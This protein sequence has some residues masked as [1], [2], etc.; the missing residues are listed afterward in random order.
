MKSRVLALLGVLL[1]VSVFNVA[2]NTG[3]ALA[4]VDVDSLL[5]TTPTPSTQ[6]ESGSSSTTKEE[7]KGQSMIDTITDNLNYT[8][9]EDETV[10]KF[11][12]M[13]Q[14]VTSWVVQGLTYV[15]TGLLV[16]NKLVD[17]F[18]VAIPFTRTILANGYMGNA[19]VAG[20]PQQTMGAMGGMGMGGMG[21]MGGYGGYNRGGLFGGFGGSRYGG[22][23]GMGMGGSMMNGAMDA[24]IASQNQPARSRLQ[25]VSN[26]ALNAVATESVLGPDGQ[27]QSAFK[28]YTK[29]MLI[30]LIIAPILVV[31][32][33]TGA[34]A[35]IGFGI[36]K[37][38][39]DIAIN[40]KF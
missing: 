24:Q 30:S 21:G 2:V 12:Q 5:T 11:G 3:V 39:S 33:A 14:K 27:G 9:P 36:G 25:I 34:V 20:T 10:K 8:T 29:D 23:G 1:L 37:L 31:L 38:I 35:K 6:E 19:N 4:A 22:M 28:T 17:L 16:I 32:S 26:A 13:V 18:Y 7:V 15:F 40:I